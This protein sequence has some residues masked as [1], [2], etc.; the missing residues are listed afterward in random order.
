MGR[1]RIIKRSNDVSAADFPKGKVIFHTRTHTPYI[2]NGTASAIW[3]FCETPK[4]VINVIEYIKRTYGVKDA[5]AK[6][7][8]E[9]FVSEMKKRNVIRLIWTKR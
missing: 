4:G 1:I 5:R 8:V 7:D 3:D 9:A 2:L 6:R